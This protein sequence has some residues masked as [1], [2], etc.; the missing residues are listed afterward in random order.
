MSAMFVS[1]LVAFALLSAGDVKAETIASLPNPLTMNDGTPVT[2]P[3]QW[4]QRRNEI[5]NMILT[6]EYGHM[7]PPPEKIPSEEESVEN[8]DDIGA[9]LHQVTLR[10][11]PNHEVPLHVGLYVPTKG[12]GPY[13]V[14]L[15][16]EPVWEEHL[17]PVAKAVVEAGYVFAGYQRHDLDRDDA[18]R[19]DGLH[20]LYPQYDWASLAVW[21]W[22][23]MRVVD[24]LEHV[25][26]VD[27]KR[28]AL[29]GHSRAGKVA[30]LAGALDQR[31]GL[32]VPHGSGAGGAGSFLI[33]EDGVETL[34]LITE[35]ERFHYWFSP[36]LA[37]FAGREKELPFDQHFLRALVAPRAVASIDGLEDQWA[38]P[39]GTRAMRA[40]AQPVFDLLQ[41]PNNNLAYFRPGGH[42]TTPEDWEVLIAFAN[43][44]FNQAPIPPEIE[45]RLAPNE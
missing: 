40:A 35:P 3:E 12:T 33:V 44:F 38:N 6:I 15:A 14:V 25:N 45:A 32:T 4:Q 21:A 20:P 18:D 23:A 43:H 8:L 36:R 24:Y 7:P 34:E 22:G 10:L 39:K 41:A 26:T 31:I 16:V 42:D 30:L 27:M 28:I 9:D 2:T 11:G 17:R 13:P 19:T 37:A 5:I 1:T 29:T